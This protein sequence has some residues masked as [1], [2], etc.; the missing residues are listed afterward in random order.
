[1]SLPR[2]RRGGSGCRALPGWEAKRGA[3][4]RE[5]KGGSLLTGCRDEK[6]G[7]RL[8][9]PCLLSARSRAG[10]AAAP[11]TETLSPGGWRRGGQGRPGRTHTAAGGDGAQPAAWAAAAAEPPSGAGCHPPSGGGSS[12]PSAPFRSAPPAAPRPP[13]HP[14]PSLPGG[15]AGQGWALAPFGCLKRSGE[16]GKCR[17][18]AGKMRGIADFV[19]KKIKTKK[20]PPK[21]PV[22]AVVII[23][24]IKSCINWVLK[25][26]P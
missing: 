19:C 26:S 2:L 17:L 12:P 8:L 3:E 1:M 25:G 23:I 4:A 9:P 24:I 5:G 16:R 6:N 7:G 21:P 10:G 18:T 14:R 11:A 20:P 15:A 13:G 22:M